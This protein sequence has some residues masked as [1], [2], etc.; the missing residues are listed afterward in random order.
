LVDPFD[1][2]FDALVPAHHVVPLPRNI[3]P[4]GPPLAGSLAV[5]VQQY[6]ASVTHRVRSHLR[7][8]EPLWQRNYY[9]HVIRDFDD[10]NGVQLYIESNP[11][12]GEDDEEH[13]NRLRD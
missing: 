7:E 6:K 9:E 3:P 4:F 10:W 2:G 1:T 8:S 11:R 5:V 12:N 13:P